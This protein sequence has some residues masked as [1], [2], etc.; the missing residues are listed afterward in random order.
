MQTRVFSWALSMSKPQLSTAKS[1][2][3]SAVH[4]WTLAKS[5]AEV[6]ER[7]SVCVGVC[8]K[9]MRRGKNTMKKEEKGYPTQKAIV[10]F[11]RQ[12]RAR[13]NKPAGRGQEQNLRLPCRD[14][15]A[16]TKHKNCEQ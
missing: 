15:M 14:K 9:H 11:C 6:E 4:S 1:C 16:K 8:V 5:L 7:V 13:S 10:P 12:L 3:H 2:G